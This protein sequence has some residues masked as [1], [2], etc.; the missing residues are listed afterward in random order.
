MKRLP[1]KTHHIGRW[2]RPG[3]SG[4]RGCSL[5]LAAALLGLTS[6]PVS[7]ELGLIFGVYTADKP[8]TVVQQFHP[9]LELLARG[10]STRLNEPAQIK[11]RI[12]ST[13]ERGVQD[14][15][16]GRVDI[17]RLGPASYVRAKELNPNITILAMESEGGTKTFCGVIAVR[18][19]SAIRDVSDLKGKSFA[20]GDKTSTIGRYLAQRYLATNGITARDLR[21]YAYLGRHDRVGAAV[22]NGEFDAGALQE[23]SFQKLVKEGMPLRAIARFPNVTKPWVA[24]EGLPPPI[25]QSL[26]AA[27]LQI[28]DREAL[29][30]LGIDGFL[31]GSD[32]DYEVTRQAMHGN[33]GFSDEA[34]ADNGR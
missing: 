26:R 13:Y 2:R 33:Y 14:I 24:R 5:G 8:T 17:S 18:T 6:G 30:R 29:R 20:F 25:V 16:A 19:D 32:A 34:S 28:N 21:R 23:S 4:L 7:A 1:G 15:A 22:G 12:A 3:T 9:V 11:M 31:D 10:L 27:L